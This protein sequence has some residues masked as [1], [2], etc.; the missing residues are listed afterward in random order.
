MQKIFFDTRKQDA[1]VRERYGLTE[2]LMME[3]AA[4]GL[5]KAVTEKLN[6][7]EKKQILVLCGAGN[8][9]ADGYALARRIIE[10]IVV[11]ECIPPKSPLCV[12]Q[13]ERA[14]KAGVK[15]V[16]SESIMSYLSCE[17]KE[18]GIVVDCIFGSGF[19]GELPEDICAVIDCV[20]GM[21]LFRLA[22]DVPTGL[23]Q[24]GNCGKSVLAADMTVTMGA[25][26]LCLYSDFAKDSCGKIQVE[27]L[28][29]PRKLFEESLEEENQ[30]E[31]W[32]LEKEDMRLPYRNK[33]NVNKGTFGH[34]VSVAGEKSGAAVMA[35]CATLRIGAGLATVVDTVGG[36]SV[37][38]DLMCSNEF[39][40]N[41][42][43]V[44][45]GMGLGRERKLDDLFDYLKNKSD[46]GCVLDA[47]LCYYSEIKDLL[48]SRS[49][50][51][52]ATVIT[53]HPKEFAALLENT[54]LGK[55]ELSQVIKNRLELSQKFCSMFP[56]VV[57]LLKG[58]TV[59]ICV[60][61]S[62]GKTRMYFNPLGSSALAKGGSGDI[63]AGLIAGLLAQKYSALDAA[64]TASLVHATASAKI[65]PDFTMTPS[66]L[67][68]SINITS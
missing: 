3:N 18:A 27:N 54:G 36:C 2:E 48:D 45:V 22:C 43:A 28:G 34:A 49:R 24:Y 11:L 26:K 16:S 37:P 1:A 25:R 57:L 47:D 31:Y 29:V 50:S 61:D 41:T 39:P 38:C 51:G 42:S 13:A 58:A 68:S 40:Q 20:N 6:E 35:S 53:P 12:I 67:L 56:G 15:T 60:N 8:N 55:H 66:I 59:L 9:G 4:A 44:A 46:A 65:K 63:L 62:N 30:T 52:A 33:Q 19:H 23:D 5:E 14:K 17:G 10:N 21:D 32:L 7:T 64:V